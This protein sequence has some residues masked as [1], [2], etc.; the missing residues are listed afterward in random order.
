MAE[1]AKKKTAFVMPHSQFQFGVM[2]FGLNQV[3][4]TFQ[5]LLDRVVKEMEEYAA[6]YLD[7]IVMFM[8]NG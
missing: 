6:V 7:D 5:W 3:P 2:P 1:S 4:A 8:L